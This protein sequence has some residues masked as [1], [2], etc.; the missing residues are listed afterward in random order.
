[1]EL[2]L[3]RHDEY[4]HPAA[5]KDFVTSDRFPKSTCLTTHMD[6]KRQLALASV[7]SQYC[8]SHA[9]SNPNVQVFFE[10]KQRENLNLLPDIRPTNQTRKAFFLIGHW[11]IRSQ[12]AGEYLRQFLDRPPILQRAGVAHFQFSKDQ[13]HLLDNRIARI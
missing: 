2:L 1:M 5:A 12:H 13:L 10:K 4:K 9:I 6:A 7:D 8:L 3:V 11:C